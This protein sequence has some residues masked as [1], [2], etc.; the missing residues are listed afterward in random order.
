MQN[1]TKQCKTKQN[2]AKQNKT[3]QCKTKQNKTMQNKTM[4]NKTKQNNAKQNKT[5]QNKT[6][7]NNAKRNKKTNIPKIASPN[8]EEVQLKLLA[9][10]PKRLCRRGDAAV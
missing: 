6:K 10:G 3:K 8:K 9:D 4:Q 7:Q 1:K 5:M 2:N